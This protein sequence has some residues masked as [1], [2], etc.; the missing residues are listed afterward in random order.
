M[1]ILEQIVEGRTD[2]VFE[3]LAEGHAA[4]SVDADGVSLIQWCA[5]YGDVSAIKFLLANGE[6]LSA[7]GDNYGLDAAC[8]HGHW[9]LC[10]FLLE[11]G[12]DANRPVPD[13][14]ETPLHAALCT[15]TRLAHNLVMKV[16][17]ANG[18]NPNCA[19]KGNVETGGFMRDVR[20]KGRNA[21]ASR[22]RFRRRRRHSDAAGCRRGN[23][24][25]GYE[26]GVAA[27]LGELACARRRFFENFAMEISAFVPTTGAAWRLICS[28]SLTPRTSGVQ[29]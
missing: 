26:W 14:G 11:R 18:G 6:S 24:R 23:R 27:Q 3:Y 15:T 19:T 20:T 17:L 21:A 10:Q 29:N 12:A 7:L 8:F 13:T 1:A 28:A 9:R 22:R 16:L 25:Q 5:Y 4:N 2:L